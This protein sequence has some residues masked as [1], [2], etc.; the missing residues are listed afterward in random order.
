MRYEVTFQ[1]DGDERTESVD[2]PDAAS[3]V[4]TVEAEHG[5]TPELFE[6]IQVQL[7]EESPPKARYRPARLANR[8]LAP[9]SLDRVH[10]RRVSPTRRPRFPTEKALIIE[11]PKSTRRRPK[12]WP[13]R[14]Y[15]LGA[16]WDGSGTNFASILRE[17]R[18]WS[19]FACSTILARSKPTGFSL[20]SRPP[21]CGTDICPSIRPGQVYGYRVHGPYQPERGHRFN[22]AKVL[23]DP[24]AKALIGAIDWSGPVFGYTRGQSTTGS[25]AR[26]CR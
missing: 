14:P 9:T 16:T 6:L 1:I 12:V 22:P 25:S 13:G 8:R 20:L 15:P 4:A 2:A 7:I 18:A 10:C 24:Y 5:R 17:R 19:N 3:A 21:M 23:L 26:R 11:P